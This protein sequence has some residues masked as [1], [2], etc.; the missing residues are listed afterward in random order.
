VK[1]II[2]AGGMGTRLQSVIEGVSKSMAPIAGKPFLELLIRQ[3][4]RWNIT[5]I[6]ISV[7]YKK[8]SIM[9][10]FCD[11]SAWSVSMKYCVED[12]PLGTGGA[13]RKA[14]CRSKSSKVLVMNG[15]SYAGG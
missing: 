9:D 7:G 6:T 12:E 8:E 15:D 1:A 5:D 4:R 14:L 10:Y 13:L 3:L 11:G 2:L